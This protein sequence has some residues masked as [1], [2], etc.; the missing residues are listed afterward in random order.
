MSQTNLT[1]EDDDLL[2]PYLWEIA[3]EIIKTA[4]ENEQVLASCEEYNL[5]YCLIDDV[6]EVEKWCVMQLSDSHIEEIDLAC[7]EHLLPAIVACWRRSVEATHTFLSHADI[8]RIAQYVP[9]AIKSVSHLAVC[10]DSARDVKG[11]IG[12]EGAMI[13]MLFIDPSFR[14]EGLGTQLLDRA[15]KEYGATLV[16]VNEQNEQAVGFYL[17]YGFEVIGRSETDGMGDP[18]P[19]L[20]MRLQAS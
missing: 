5:P 16:D 3:Q 13:E 4:I 15:V 11:F 17:H 10:F 14:G 6:Y 7:E 1:P 12:V 8:D 20:H 18:F 9:D 2:T 19:I